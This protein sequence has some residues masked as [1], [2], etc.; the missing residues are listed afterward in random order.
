MLTLLWYYTLFY[1][2]KFE[3]KKALMYAAS[4]SIVFGIIIEV[5]QG[6][7]TASRSADIYDVMANTI[8]VFLA[9]VILFIKNLITIKK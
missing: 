3:N 5:L 2:V 6:T 4:F 8:G 1:T 7:V 9:V